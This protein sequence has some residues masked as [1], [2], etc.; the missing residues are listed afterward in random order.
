[1]HTLASAWRQES[2]QILWPR[3]L[4]G[5]R[6]SAMTAIVLEDARTYEPRFRSLP[7]PVDFSF[8]FRFRFEAWASPWLSCK[9]CNSEYVRHFGFK[10][11]R[12]SSGFHQMPGVQLSWFRSG[13][14]EFKSKPDRWSITTLMHLRPR[15][16][17]WRN[18][19]RMFQP[20]R[21]SCAGLRILTRSRKIFSIRTLRKHTYL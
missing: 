3:C 19:A 5:H 2:R 16:L 18:P 13:S 9:F 1:M 4:P 14:F 17:V 6:P 11:Q 21:A 12:L 20:F 10:L 8:P 7:F 15:I